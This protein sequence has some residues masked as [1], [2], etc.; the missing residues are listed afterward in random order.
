MNDDTQE[1]LHNLF[2]TELF[3]KLYLFILEVLSAQNCGSY[4]LKIYF[5]SVIID[6]IICVTFHDGAHRGAIL[7]HLVRTRVSPPTLAV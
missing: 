5:S 7:V 3:L 2:D 6:A 1:K 4:I